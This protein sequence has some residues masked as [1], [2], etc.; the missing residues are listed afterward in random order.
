MGPCGM[1]QAEPP[2]I[3]VALSGGGHRA[4][5]F[6]LGAL[7]YLADAGANAH[8]TSISSVS[9]GSIANGAVCARVDFT[10]DS[11]EVEGAVSTIAKKVASRRW[12]PTGS[13][14]VAFLGILLMVAAASLVG[15]WWLPVDLGWR[16]AVL[17]G[18]LSV[19]AAATILGLTGGGPL[20]GWSGTWAYLAGLVLLAELVAV[21]TPQLK[22][23][24][25]LRDTLDVV[26][27]PQ[28]STSTYTVLVLVVIGLLVVAALLSLRGRVCGRAFAHTLLPSGPSTKMANLPDRL[29]PVICATEL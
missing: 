9:G 10:A 29:D 14:L 26:G 5:L 7:L 22:D 6:G 28:W 16:I 1:D 13:W 25:L 11:E 23:T 18:G 12:A 27:R 19:L 17:I 2:D 15:V 3:A 4:C 21:G 8:V 20:F 24:A